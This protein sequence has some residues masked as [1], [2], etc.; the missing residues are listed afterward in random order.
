MSE[1]LFEVLALQIRSVGSNVVRRSIWRS[2]ENGG[3]KGCI[4]LLFPL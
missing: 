1:A 4:N 2:A 3:L